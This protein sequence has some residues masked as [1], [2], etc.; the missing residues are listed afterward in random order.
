MGRKPPLQKLAGTGTMDI[1]SYE[2]G[3]RRAIPDREFLVD[4]R[5]Y[6]YQSLEPL[7]TI[8]I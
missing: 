8:D 6:S 5:P 4:I 7:N 1:F 2:D 3:H